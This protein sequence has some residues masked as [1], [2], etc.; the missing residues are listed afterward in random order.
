MW[1]HNYNTSHETN[2]I[3]SV[4]SYRNNALKIFNSTLYP[5]CTAEAFI[6]SVP[7][8][9]SIIH[10]NTLYTVLWLHCRGFHNREARQSPPGSSSM[11]YTNR[12]KVRQRNIT[13][14]FTIF[15]E[16]STYWRIFAANFIFFLL[17]ICWQASQCQVKKSCFCT[18]LWKSDDAMKQI[19]LKK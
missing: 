16:S 2:Y 6:A 13:L 19:F 5:V 3:I 14:I 1:F 18:C 10:I 4:W 15:R 11:I 12:V 9:A 17:R 8:E 7:V